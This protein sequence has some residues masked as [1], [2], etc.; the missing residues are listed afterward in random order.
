MP[1]LRAA[2]VAADAGRLREFSRAAFE[3][4]FLEG[5]GLSEEADLRAVSEE[6]GLDPDLMLAEIRCPAV[7]ESL[8]L[9]TESAIRA[10]VFGVPTVLVG[11]KLFWGDDHLGEVVEALGG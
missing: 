7:K 5:R 8:K 11:E 10:G 3:R 2:Y 4:N 9:E 6:A 1:A